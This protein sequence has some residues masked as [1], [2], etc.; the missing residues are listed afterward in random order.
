MTAASSCDAPA[1]I[2]RLLAISVSLSAAIV[3]IVSLPE[4]PD[5]QA[6][7]APAH[8]PE[9]RI[10]RSLNNQ[11]KWEGRY[12]K[13]IERLRRRG[14]LCRPGRPEGCDRGFLAAGRL[15]RVATSGQGP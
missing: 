4:F 5:R 9:R 15:R 1:A 10:R 6:N 7:P 8:W 14:R 3:G 11:N 2:S 12:G 13:Q